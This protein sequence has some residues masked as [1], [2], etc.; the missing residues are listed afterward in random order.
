V[1]LF[2]KMAVTFLML[3]RC[4]VL[5]KVS[6]VLTSTIIIAKS[7]LQVARYNPDTCLNK[8]Q[9]SRRICLVNTSASKYIKNEA[10]KMS[11]T[12]VKSR[13]PATPA[14]PAQSSG[15]AMPAIVVLY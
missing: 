2:C 5:R 12:L 6:V 14:A 4:Y 8:Y 1:S 13:L 9:C 10:E 15:I 7:S 3:T 11:H